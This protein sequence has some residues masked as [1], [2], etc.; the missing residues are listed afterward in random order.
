MQQP[1]KSAWNLDHRVHKSIP[2]VTKYNGVDF[3][4]IWYHINN[5]HDYMHVCVAAS[6]HDPAPVAAIAI[7]SH[8]R[9][10]SC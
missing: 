2:S 10:S 8:Q 4:D 3:Y 7:F 9:Y 5:M 1:L 6:M